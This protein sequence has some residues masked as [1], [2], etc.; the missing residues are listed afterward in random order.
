MYY[1]LKEY[2][3]NQKK[4]AH[5]VT[6]VKA[7]SAVDAVR[8]VTFWRHARDFVVSRNTHGVVTS[9]HTQDGDGKNGCKATLI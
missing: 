3:L 6:T 2:Y 7:E 8:S 9:A 1:Q 4:P 5:L